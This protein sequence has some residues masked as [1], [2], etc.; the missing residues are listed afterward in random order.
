MEGKKS[1]SSV[2]GHGRFKENCLG[3]NVSLTVGY[4][5]LC[6]SNKDAIALWA[7]SCETQDE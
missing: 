1:L 2:T 4:I 6:L 3:E 7:F 5:V